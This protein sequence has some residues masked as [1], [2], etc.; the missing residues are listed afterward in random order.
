M[1]DR[2]V[3]TQLT[4]Q[5]LYTQGA[6]KMDYMLTSMWVDKHGGF[7]FTFDGDAGSA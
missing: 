4:V 3:E 1:A 7:T 6:R 5:P 2:W